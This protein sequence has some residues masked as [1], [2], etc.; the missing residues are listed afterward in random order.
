MLLP[1]GLWLGTLEVGIQN[2]QWSQ[3][4]MLNPHLQL[5]AIALAAFDLGLVPDASQTLE[6]ASERV[7]QDYA[8]ALQRTETRDADR[9]ATSLAAQ[10]AIE[11]LSQKN[12]GEFKEAVDQGKS[13]IAEAIASLKAV[14]TT[15]LEFMKLAAPVDYWTTKAERH[16]RTTRRR[17]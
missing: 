16:E 12:S 11:A 15:Y 4:Q 17:R 6:K 9:H 10:Q 3:Q 7:L 14:R 13:E 1:S 2:E 8:A 5:G